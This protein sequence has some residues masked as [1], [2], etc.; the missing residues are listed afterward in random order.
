MWFQSD[1]TVLHCY[2]FNWNQ[3]R[4]ALR[5]P[6]SWINMNRFKFCV[7]MEKIWFHT[8]CFIFR[9]IVHPAEM[10]F[11]M[12]NRWKRKNEYMKCKTRPRQC[13]SARDLRDGFSLLVL[14]FLDWTR[15]LFLRNQSGGQEYR[16]SRAKAVL[17]P[18]VI[19]WIISILSSCLGVKPQQKVICDQRN[20]ELAV[21]AI[22]FALTADLG[23]FWVVDF[24]KAG[25]FRLRE[26]GDQV[27]CGIV[28]PAKINQYPLRS[29]EST[30]S[31]TAIPKNRI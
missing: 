15:A 27:A 19:K 12:L 25:I 8:T 31:L 4:E 13:I 22:V 1:I 5:V 28:G 2:F 11:L 3:Q 10:P 30:L 17:S 14:V 7:E 26:S 6:E 23:P 9:S 20:S 21:C 16:W 18:F 29:S 24:K